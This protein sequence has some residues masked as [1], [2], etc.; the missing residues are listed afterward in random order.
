VKRAQRGLTI[1]DMGEMSRTSGDS[2]L[3]IPAIITA[4]DRGAA[5]SIYGESKVYLEVGGRTMVASVVAAL[6]HVPEVS[7]VWVVGDAARLNEVLSEKGLVDQLSKPL[8]ISEQ[9][10]NLY[11]NAWQTYRQTL[12][13]APPEGRDPLVHELDSQVLYLSGDLPFATPQEI[14]EFIRRG[15]ELDCDY[16]LGLVRDVA[17]EAFEAPN[18]EA[19]GLDIACFNL[20]DGRLK[21]NN[22]HLAKPAQITNRDRIEDLYRHRHMREF[23]NMVGLISSLFIKNGGAAIVFVYLVM[24]LAGYAD[25]RGWH[26]VRDLI[27]SIV[28]VKHNEWGISRLMGCDFRFVIGDV[29]GCAVDVDTEEEYDLVCARYDEWMRAER[30]RAEAVL[31]PV[32][33]ARSS[34]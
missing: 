14:S 34:S 32:A 5:K 17:F 8:H 15:Q 18:A 3:G 21:Q 6:Q 30:E 2:N 28:T 23:R 12:P 25:R 26:R 10:A 19:P 11:E 20:R 16:A 33:P 29:G 9:H 7:E 4:G 27:R 31:G 13:G 1:V 22:L 24:H